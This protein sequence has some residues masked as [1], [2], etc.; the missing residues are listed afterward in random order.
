M[1]FGHIAVSLY[2][3]WLNTD[4]T[5]MATVIFALQSDNPPTSNMIHAPNS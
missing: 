2:A 1:H 3:E 5:V 4:S